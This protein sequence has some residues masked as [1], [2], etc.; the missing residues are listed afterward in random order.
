MIKNNKGIAL[1]T[2][3]VTVII[4]LTIVGTITYKSLDMIKIRKLDDMY[5]DIRVLN[6]KITSYYMENNALPILETVIAKSSLPT[7]IR[8]H[9]VNDND[10]YYI[11]DLEKLGGISLKYGKQY[12]EYATNN[13]K[14]DVY[15]INEATQ[16]IY[17]LKGITI[18]GVTKHPLD[19]TYVQIALPTVAPTVTPT[20]PFVAKSINIYYTNQ[21]TN[22]NGNTVLKYI[23]NVYYENGVS[24]KWVYGDSKVVWWS[25]SSIVSV[26]STTGEVT[27]LGA[28]EAVICV[29]TLDGG[30]E[31]SQTLTITG[32]TILQFYIGEILYRTPQGWT[33]EQW[34]ADTTYNTHG[35]YIQNNKVWN[36]DGSKYVGT[37][38][39]T[40]VSPT[41]VIDGSCGLY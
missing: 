10:N 18:D 6:Q 29:A 40:P 30:A 26:D 9:N 33:W 15:I 13:T 11:I 16:T 14:K 34:V 21:G 27:I 8:N 38:A 23:A 24:T 28:G 31:A 12:K 4:M 20:P 35:F 22:E 41:D 7:S 25:D 1:G 32:T 36:S 5:S 19:D 39:S 3:V 2:L 17:Y 37:S